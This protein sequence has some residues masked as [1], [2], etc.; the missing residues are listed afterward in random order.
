MTMFAAALAGLVIGQDI[1]ASRPAVFR[2]VF[3]D[4]PRQLVIVLN[5][6][7]KQP[8]IG[9]VFH[10]D[11]AS[12]RKVWEGTIDYRGKVYD[13]SQNNS[14]SEGRVIWEAESEAI[15]LP[16]SANPAGW[17]FERVTFDGS[18][19]FDADGAMLRSPEFNLGTMQTVYVGFD[20]MSTTGPLI[21]RLVGADG[22]VLTQ[23]ESSTAQDSNWQW[24]YKRIPVFPGQLHLEVSQPS[25]AF[26]KRVRNLRVFGDYPVWKLGREGRA[27]PADTAL[28]RYRLTTDG[29]AIVTSRV[30]HALVDWHPQA[31]DFGWKETF[32]VR[33]LRQGQR[34]VLNRSGLDT[35]PLILENGTTRREHA[36]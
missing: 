31:N 20:E 21:M 35:V 8:P 15:R 12:I 13:F 29:S 25:L 33:G 10:P 30:G 11:I 6:N 4:R 7:G 28:V 9:F 19:R 1:A 34:L 22:G 3:E 32:T 16:D 14:R 5:R 24:N 27:E 26:R 2:A 18:W 17:T 23:F 36:R